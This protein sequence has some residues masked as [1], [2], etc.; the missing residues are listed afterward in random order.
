MSYDSTIKYLIEEF[1]QPIMSWLLKEN[2]EQKPEFLPTELNVEP[3][4]ADGVFF[5]K[6]R[7][8]VIHLEFQTLPQ[9]D[10]PIP[11]RMLDYWVRIHRIYPNNK[12]EQ[13]LVFLKP[14][15]SPE[16]F[17][18]EFK[19]PSNIHRYQV[20]RIWECDPSLLLDKP[21]L[22]PLAVLAK[23]DNPEN[24]LKQVSAQVNT[25][26]N[27]RLK[28][29]VSAC[30]QILAGINF[31]E[32]LIKAYFQEDIMKESVIY[33][34]IINE[35]KQEGRQEVKYSEIKLINRLLN[36]HLGEVNPQISQKIQELSF[37]QLEDLGEAL[38]DFNSESD[39]ANWLDENAECRI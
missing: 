20:V 21:E 2:L 37:E 10:P 1:T 29:N 24:L 9:S 18:N 36:R 31:K 4:R 19:S 6:V 25:I 13:I 15:N 16:V 26:E 7:S 39:L 38:L 12:I 8:K 27:R 14:T 30:T 5:L 32:D 17:I 28:S 22:L 23:A 33:Q 11:F 3:I 35:G 34:K